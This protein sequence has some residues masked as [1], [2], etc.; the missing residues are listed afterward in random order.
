L[1]G[2]QARWRAWFPRDAHVGVAFVVPMVLILGGVVGIPFVYAIYISFHDKILGFPGLPYVGLDN[3]VKIL[4]L[5]DY[6]SAVGVSV[7][8]TLACVPTKLVIGFGLAL[9]LNQPI[10]GRT[11]ARGLVMLPWACPLLV[12]VVV[13]YFLLNDVNGVF[14]W[15]LVWSG[16]MSAPISWVGRPDTALPT[17][18]GVSIWRGFPFFAVT[19]LAALQSIPHELYE[20]AQVDGASAFR[21]LLHITI[22][23][24]RPVMM[25]VTLLSTIWTFNEFTLVWTLTR[26]GPAGV[27]TVLPV[28]TYTTAMI[29]GELS[30]GVAISVTVMPILLALIA[31]LVGSLSREER[32][33]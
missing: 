7:V 29:G 11:A 2:I 18:I 9:I 5:S 16:I 4:Q 17:L 14:N 25:V 26:G 30:R 33:A 23:A 12:V 8:Y 31:L 15:L 1:G 24:V 22:P 19:L 32:N 13:W 20:A 10:P 21:R 28:L 27:T 3:Y 6:W